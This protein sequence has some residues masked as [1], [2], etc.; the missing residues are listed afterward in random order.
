MTS[1][2]TSSQPFL[3][4]RDQ[5]IGDFYHGQS[6]AYYDRKGNLVKSEQ[7]LVLLWSNTGKDFDPDTWKTFVPRYT[8]Y[9]DE[10][11]EIIP[12]PENKTTFSKR[13]DLQNANNA[14]SV[15]LTPPTPLKQQEAVTIN[16]IDVPKKSTNTGI[17]I[18]Q[19]SLQNPSNKQKISAPEPKKKV[20]KPKIQDE[21]SKIDEKIVEMVVEQTKYDVEIAIEQSEIQEF[22]AKE[23]SKTEIEE[24]SVKK[25]KNS[26]EK[27][28]NQKKNV[29]V[30]KN[31]P[32]KAKK[33]RKSSKKGKK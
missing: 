14:N 22:Y 28:K 25:Q 2:I 3:M 31:P 15:S 10:K 33:N 19:R 9:V 11:G 21:N 1:S 4:A 30:R 13:D 23:E 8:M 20:E 17:D 29:I 18:L 12:A 5:G 7:R 6:I 16:N 32:R 24:P 26:L 27:K